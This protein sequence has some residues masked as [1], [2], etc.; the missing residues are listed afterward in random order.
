MKEINVVP[1]RLAQLSGI[2]HGACGMDSWCFGP[3]KKLYMSTSPYEKEAGFIVDRT[4][5]KW[6]KGRPYE[7]C[8]VGMWLCTWLMFSA[9]PEWSGVIKGA[10]IFCMYCLVNAVFYTMLNANGNVYM[11][12]AFKTQDEYVALNTYGGIIPM[13]TAFAFNIAF[14]V[15]M[16]KIATSPAGWSRLVAVI[17]VPLAAFGMLRFLTIKETHEVEAVSATEKISLKDVGMILRHNRYIYILAIATLVMNFVTNMGI[18]TYY[19][20]YIVGN[21]GLMG[22]L[23]VVQIVIIPL[24]FVFPPIIRKFSKQKLIMAGVLTTCVGLFINFIAGSNMTLLMIGALLQNAGAVPISMLAS[25]LIVDCAEYNEWKGMRRMEGTLGS[26][27]GFASKVGGSLGTAFVGIMIGLAGYDASAAVMP[28]SAILMIR[29]LYS[30][31]PLALYVVVFIAMGFYKVEK[32]MPQILKD[33]EEDALHILQ[34]IRRRKI[35][36]LTD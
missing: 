7:W 32:D 31:I 13:L 35:N 22:A 8:I 9:S 25:L 3:G 28:D 20:T 21:V 6:G 18:N 33:N 30:L 34:S 26:V 23:S 17:A 16:A 15:A 19:F 27:N 11:V 10:W 5:T 29:L 4:H 14:P 1:Y 12:R 2:V 36:K 24:M